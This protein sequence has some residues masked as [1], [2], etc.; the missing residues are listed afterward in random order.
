MS[1]VDAGPPIATVNPT[2]GELL[3]IFE[4]YD[5]VA[6]ETRLAKAAAAARIWARSTFG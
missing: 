1:P 4:P 2:T 6:V 3:Q 5:A